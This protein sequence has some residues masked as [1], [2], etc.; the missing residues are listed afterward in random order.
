MASKPAAKTDSGTNDAE[1]TNTNDGGNPS[2][3]PTV[4]SDRINQEDI[5]FLVTHYLAN[6]HKEEHKESSLDPERKEALDRIRRATN[7]IA[8]AFSTLGAYGTSY[9][10]SDH[11]ELDILVTLIY[12]CCPHTISLFYRL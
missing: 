8:S 10:V 1:P 7:E 12:I 2:T 6:F 5:P 4:P 3:A 9:R 11:V